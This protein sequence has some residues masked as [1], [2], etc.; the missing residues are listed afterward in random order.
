M[1]FNSYNYIIIGAGS[2]GCVLANRLSADPEINVL[3]I[4]SGPSDKTWKTSMP[5]ALL[6]TMHDPKYNYLYETEPEPFMNNRKMF[7]P[8]GKMLGG[9]SSHNGMVHV[10][11]NPMDFENW[12]Q[13]DLKS[14][15]YNNVLPYFKKS[16]SIEGLDETYRNRSGPLKLSR[17]SEGNE[18]SKVYLE[19][20]EQAGYE[21]NNDMNGYKQEGFGLMDTT[22]YG[23]RRQSTS[24]TYLHPVINRRNLTVITNTIVN[25]VIIENN[26]AVGVECTAGREIKK[27][28]ADNE[29]ILSAG[30][31]NSPQLLML[32][33]IGSAEELKK[34]DISVQHDLRGVG[35]NLQDHLETY[36]QYE[37]TK[38]VT[39]YTSYNPIRMAFIGIEWFIFK[40]GV[41][42]YSNLETGGF[43][44]SNDM[45]DYPNIQYHFFPSLV[46]DHGRQS[47]SSHSFQAHVG[48]M[49][50]TSRGHVKLKSNNPSASPA[51]QFNYM[52]TEHDLKEMRDGIKIAREIFHQKAFDKYRGK[53]INPGINS[54]SEGDLN[55]FIKN[56][57]D[58]AYHPSCTCKMG[59]DELSVVDEELKVYGIENLRVVDASIMPNIIT[60]NLNATTVMIAEKASDLIL[61]KETLPDVETSFYRA[62]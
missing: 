26:K 46:L 52:Q 7:C 14:W 5:A 30:A 2:A 10:R 41:A 35:E 45:V 60:G 38:P 43:V 20:A 24:V 8:R 53:E 57:G 39:L 3:L 22:I 29:V 58:T 54:S 12:A 17:S 6:Y 4:E 13:K 1:Q 34:L 48:P 9:S 11:G 49:R 27:I 56:K 31:I 37:C 61:K 51:I 32:S 47:P 55:E 36:L 33:G 25:K 40:S 21:I 19:A 16:E 15:N 62:S 28:Y 18:L 42:A 44:R 50:P 59:K 23:G